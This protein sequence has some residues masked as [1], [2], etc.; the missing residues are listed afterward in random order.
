METDKKKIYHA[1]DLNWWHWQGEEKYWNNNMA[2]N[3]KRSVDQLD[4]E[5]L[6]AAFLPLDPRLG[7][8]YYWGM[9]YFLE[10]VPVKAVFPMHCWDH[11]EICQKVQDEPSMQGL[12][13]HFHPIEYKGQEWTLC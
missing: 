12:L 13:E 3:Y 7:S 11:Y 9:K 2:S 6:D 5:T 4:G 10:H 1:G 8:A